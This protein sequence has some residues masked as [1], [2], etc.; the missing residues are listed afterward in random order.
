MRTTFTKCCLIL[1]FV[2]AGSEIPIHAQCADEGDV[3]SFNFNGHF[4]EV[5]R[6]LKTWA[7]AASCA[8]ERG[9]SLAEINTQAEQDTIYM[10]IIHGAAIA[11]DY[12]TVTDGGGIA[13]VWIGA[14]DLH[15]EGTWLWD[16]DGDNSGINFW[17][18][19]G[20]AGLGDGAPVDQLYNN[21]GGSSSG[22]PNE[23]DDYGA[24]QDGAA[25][26]LAKWPAG[27]DFTL[28]IASE[29]NDISSDNTLYFVVEYDCTDADTSVTQNGSILTANRTGAEYQ[30]LDCNND[31]AVI[32]GETGQSFTPTLSGSYAVEIT[33]DGCID[34]SACHVYDH[35]VGINNGFK[36]PVTA[37]QGASSDEILVDLGDVYRDIMVL[38]TDVN[39]RVVHRESIARSQAFQFV[40]EE[41]PGIYFIA[42]RSGD[43]QGIIKLGKN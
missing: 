40:L 31:H 18:G 10:S 42:V 35:A 19:Q 6:S 41:P 34:T 24:G 37:W 22:D 23:P 32:E 3:Y 33:E 14:S 13:Y 17:N 9:G 20:T 43:K 39:G 12:T 4:Y 5:I 2:T 15:T 8:V 1:L 21:W 26:G 11:A 36:Q 38:V 25:I 27:A 29:W 30:W 28:G 7:N 16:G